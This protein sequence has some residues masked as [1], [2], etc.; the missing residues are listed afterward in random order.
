MTRYIHFWLGFAVMLA[1]VPQL[2]FGQQDGGEDTMETVH[3]VGFIVLFVFVF[4][5]IIWLNRRDEKKDD[6]VKSKINALRE[7]GK[8]LHLN[9][10][11]PLTAEDIHFIEKH[12]QTSVIAATVVFAAIAVMFFVFGNLIFYILGAGLLVMI[13]PTRKYI[14]SGTQS[15]IDKGEKQ[16]IRGIITD[17]YTTS[18][19]SSKSRTTHHWLKLGDITFEVSSSK[20]RT[21]AVG[22]AAEFHTVDY[23]V[24]KPFIIRD[25]KL[26]SAGLK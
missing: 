20:Y 7:S 14:R 24:G 11:E 26:E 3:I 6:A 18:T 22:D 2:A 21:Y 15:V 23:P 10:T 12:A 1:M 16:V 4:V 25:T 19:G 13:I 8:E 9:R 17:R 5:L